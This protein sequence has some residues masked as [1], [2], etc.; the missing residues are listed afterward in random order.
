[1]KKLM[2]AVFLALLVSVVSF[3]FSSS[4]F[5]ALDCVSLENSR[6]AMS[7][8]IPYDWP[9]AL[10]SGV[11]T[12]V[13]RMDILKVVKVSVFSLLLLGGIL[14]LLAWRDLG[15]FLT[16]TAEPSLVERKQTGWF[17]IGFL[18]F[19][20]VL[21]FLSYKQIWAGLKPKKK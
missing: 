8:S 16:W 9:I 15:A 20:T 13:Q 12:G 5:A 21:A 10:Y 6:K 2:T 14:V 19:A 1:M 11:I 4:A 17:V 7:D 3:V 18:L